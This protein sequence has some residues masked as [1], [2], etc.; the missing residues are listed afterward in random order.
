MNFTIMSSYSD[1]RTRGCTGGRF[2]RS[3]CRSEVGIHSIFYKAVAEGFQTKTVSTGISA[4]A[5][6]DLNTFSLLRVS[7]RCRWE[8]RLGFFQPMRERIRLTCSNSLAKGPGIQRD[9]AQIL[10]NSDIS[11]FCKSWRNVSHLAPN[12]FSSTDYVLRCVQLPFQPALSTFR[13]PALILC[14]VSPHRRIPLRASAAST[15]Q[16][17]TARAMSIA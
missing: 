3:E 12:L 17:P 11:L 8:C 10:D 2:Y 13:Q 5:S 15:L 4:W 16:A 6:R 14:R 7:R 9:I 1:S